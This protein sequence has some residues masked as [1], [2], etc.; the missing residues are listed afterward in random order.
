[1]DPLNRVQSWTYTTGA[2]VAIGG[3][4][5]PSGEVKTYKDAKNRVTSYFYSSAGDLRR[6]VDPVGYAEE[7]DY[8]GIGRRV[9]HRSIVDATTRIT[10]FSYDRLSRLT[11]TVEPPVTNEITGNTHTVCIGQSYSTGTP[12]RPSRSCWI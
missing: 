8:D 2:E 1:M 11:A 12:I 3:G 7:F 4:L 10:T 6:V 9:T 5:T